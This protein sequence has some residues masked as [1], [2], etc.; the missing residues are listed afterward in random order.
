M[1]SGVFVLVQ[2]SDFEE[3]KTAAGAGAGALIAQGVE[4]G[5][6]CRERRRS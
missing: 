5:D 1:P 6:T 4:A 3:A 2:V